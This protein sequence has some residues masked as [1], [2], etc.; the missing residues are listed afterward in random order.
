MA[1]KQSTADNITK[2]INQLYASGCKNPT[3]DQVREHLGGGSLATISPILREW[4]EQR[5]L[6]IAAAIA[7]PAELKKQVEMS[8]E[9]IW[10]V[11]GKL[12]KA[13]YESQRENAENATKEALAE[14]D[15][16]L[17]EITRL[18]SEVAT[19]NTELKDIEQTS[20]SLQTAIESERLKNAELTKVSKTLE[21]RIEEKDKRIVDLNALLKNAQKS[22]ANL[23]IQ[24]I[25]IAGKSKGTP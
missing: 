19:L 25:K 21:A 9:N 10:Q 16:A 1:I 24:L 4:K 2:A 11:A 13:S 22:Q 7:M 17:T 12:A 15:E 18:E 5:S 23:E 6:Q 14:R 8:I 3:N 20:H